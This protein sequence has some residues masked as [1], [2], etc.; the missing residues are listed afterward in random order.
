LAL[1]LALAVLLACDQMSEQFVELQTIFDSNSTLTLKETIYKAREWANIASKEKSEVSTTTSSQPRVNFSEKLLIITQFVDGLLKS[2]VL[3]FVPSEEKPSSRNV[4]NSCNLFTVFS[5]LLDI[6]CRAGS[7]RLAFMRVEEWLHRFGTIVKSIEDNSVNRQN[8]SERCNI[9][10]NKEHNKPTHIYCYKYRASDLHVVIKQLRLLQSRFILFKHDEIENWISSFTSL[11]ADNS[12]CDE[13]FLR[14]KRKRYSEQAIVSHPLLEDNSY[15]SLSIYRVC[16]LIAELC[17]RLKI[18]MV[19]QQLAQEI[20]HTFIILS[21][22]KS[23]NTCPHCSSP[24]GMCSK[25]FACS[26]HLLFRSVMGV[27]KGEELASTE[28][29]HST[30]DIAIRHY[31]D[32]SSDLC[33]MLSSDFW[34]NVCGSTGGSATSADVAERKCEKHFS[35]AA[36]AALLLAK[37]VIT[38]TEDACKIPRL[39]AILRELKA[40]LGSARVRSLVFQ[41]P[42]NAFNFH[43]TD[44]L[45]EKVC[46][47]ELQYL[48][49][50]QY[51]V[52]Y[53]QGTV[54][55]TVRT[56]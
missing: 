34:V 26:C 20:F 46:E 15:G 8:V 52:S 4:V 19:L 37:K 29:V 9:S 38:D 55:S 7:K 50:V 47:F 53:W 21:Q 1:E 41:N 32:S 18:P 22:K 39:P 30:V 43:S 51:D 12:G 28:N 17:E 56:S 5:V 27:E 10:P 13:D 16:Y 49:T 45:Q 54:A 35:V 11:L 3:G 25:T 23:V 42:N 6:L 24:T 31:S 14:K 48:H 40:V 33:E 36:V 44:A 2:P